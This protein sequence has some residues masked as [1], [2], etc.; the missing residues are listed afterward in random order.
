[1]YWTIIESNSPLVLNL[2]NTIFLFLEAHVSNVCM[3]YMYCSRLYERKKWERIIF[4]FLF[5]TF[6]IES[7]LQTRVGKGG[8][9]RFEFEERMKE[10]VHINETLD[11]FLLVF[12]HADGICTV[13]VKDSTYKAHQS[14][15]LAYW[16]TPF[17]V[18]YVF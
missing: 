12:L 3:L 7:R 18:L 14:F 10:G 15:F 11:L 16:K 17:Q 2:K 9:A 6:S 4:K 8:K 5:K 13:N 1:M